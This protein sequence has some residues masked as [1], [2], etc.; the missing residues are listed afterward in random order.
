[1]SH[2]RK[3]NSHEAKL[4]K[5]QKTRYFD[6][7][8]SIGCQTHHCNTGVKENHQLNPEWPGICSACLNTCLNTC[9]CANAVRTTEA[10]S[11]LFSR[12]ENISAEYYFPLLSAKQKLQQTTLYLFT[13][14][15]YLPKKIRRGVH[16]NPLPSRGFT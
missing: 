3:Q 9:A 14:Y 2:H 13:F 15:F 16:M 6:T 11:A 8:R 1:M 7:W 12:L 5:R 4:R 10:D